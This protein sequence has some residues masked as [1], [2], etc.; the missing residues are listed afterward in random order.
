MFNVIAKLNT[1]DRLLDVEDVVE[2]YGFSPSKVYRMSEAKQI[3]AAMMGGT[4]KFDP[5]A[6]AMWTASKDPNI[7]KAYRLLLKENKEAQEEYLRQF[8][9]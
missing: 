1:Y 6:L 7:A 4:W 5:S 3:P 9:N 8:K 2:V